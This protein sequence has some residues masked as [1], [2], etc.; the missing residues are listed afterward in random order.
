M[1]IQTRLPNPRAADAGA[2]EAARKGGASPHVARTELNLSLE[3]G[4]R[5]ERIFRRRVMRGDG[6][7]PLP[8]YARHGLHVAAVMAQGGYPALSERRM[9][10]LG[11]CV[12]LPLTRPPTSSHL[13]EDA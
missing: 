9:G 12:C 8:R 6:E 4:A 7:G 3:V 1:P 10:K 13:L 5:F 11:A 2:Y